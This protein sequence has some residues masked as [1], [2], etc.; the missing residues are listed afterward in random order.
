[1]FLPF[2]RAASVGS[3][4]R[5]VASAA[6]DVTPNAV[7]W[8][9]AS[10]S[11]AATTNTQTITGINTSINLSISWSGKTT[12]ALNVYKNGV[13]IPIADEDSP[14]TLS[15]VNND[16]IYFYSSSAGAETVNFT[17]TNLSDGN[18]VLDT[19]TIELFEEV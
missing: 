18:T 14:Y 5:P 2:Q 16:A 1:M 7:N 15:V 8:T 9:N 3:F 12:G 13:E 17:V 6:A 11:G 19:F 4:R 10:G